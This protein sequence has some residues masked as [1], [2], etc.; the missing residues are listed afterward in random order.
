[1]SAFRLLKGDTDDPDVRLALYIIVATIPAAIAGL[2]LE[3]LEDTLSTPN[4]IAATLIGVA[5]LLRAAELGGERKKELETMSLFDA[6]MIGFSQM[7]AIIPGVSRSGITITAGL[8]RGMTR[9]GAAQ[10]SFLLSAPIVGG[11]VAKKMFD[12]AKDGLP[13]GQGTPFV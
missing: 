13:T 12:V 6:L 2:I 1:K 4:V 5:L 3:R 10:F 9:K 7:T 8:F 11:A